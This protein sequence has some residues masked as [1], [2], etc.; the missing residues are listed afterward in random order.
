MPLQTYLILEKKAITQNTKFWSSLT[1]GRAER[2]N[3]SLGFVPVHLEQYN[4]TS[5]VVICIL[6]YILQNKRRN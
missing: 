1:P 4:S 5:S 3:S 2:M 6:A